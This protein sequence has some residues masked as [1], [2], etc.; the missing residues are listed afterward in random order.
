MALEEQ[1]LGLYRKLQDEW[2]VARLLNNLGYTASE[3]GDPGR[4]LSLL[5]EALAIWGSMEDK[6]GVAY[7]LHNQGSVAQG[8]GELERAA[9]LFEQA[10]ALWRELGDKRNARTRC[11]VLGLWPSSVAVSARAWRCLKRR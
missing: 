5:E 11:I 3:A 6:H 1:S 7:V 9:A 4:A 10:L 2:N 8:Q